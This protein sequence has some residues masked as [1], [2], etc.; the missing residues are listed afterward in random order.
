MLDREAVF[1]V[2]IANSSQ[3]R[4]VTQTKRSGEDSLN[5]D[6][7]EPCFL[8][9]LQTRFEF[10]DDVDDV[11]PEAQDLIRRLICSPIERFGKNGLRDFRGH[12]WFSSIDW[13]SIRDSKYMSLVLYKIVM[14]LNFED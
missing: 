9:Y 11:S 3:V 10:L 4:K 12:S 13:D 1:I 8:L 6:L 7:K 5:C 2:F 14:Y